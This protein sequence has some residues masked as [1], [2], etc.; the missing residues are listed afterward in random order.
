MITRASSYMMDWVKDSLILIEILISQNG[1]DSLMAQETPYIKGVRRLDF[2]KLNIIL[3]LSD[4]LHNV[5]F[6]YSSIGVEWFEPL[7][8]STKSLVWKKHLAW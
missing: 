5:D 3:N 6:H 2:F 8:Q 4:F 7:Y 1:F